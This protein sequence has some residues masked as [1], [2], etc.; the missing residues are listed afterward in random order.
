MST[1][2]PMQ[3]YEA[4]KLTVFGFGGEPVLDHIDLSQCRDGIAAICRE[5]GAEHVAF[6]LT[7]VKLMPSGLLGLLASLKQQLGVNVM[8][9]N[10]SDDIREVLE[11]TRLDRLMEVHELAL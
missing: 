10:P 3:V 8:L 2:S 9:Y 11:I 5:H 6:D 4:G 1:S 7:G